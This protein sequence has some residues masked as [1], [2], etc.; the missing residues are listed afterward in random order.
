MQAT[1]YFITPNVKF[2]RTISL[3][4]YYAIDS[5]KREIQTSHNFEQ[6]RDVMPRVEIFTKDEYRFLADRESAFLER[7]NGGGKKG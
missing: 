6:L 4:S 1:R 5:D 3:N 7:K 2:L